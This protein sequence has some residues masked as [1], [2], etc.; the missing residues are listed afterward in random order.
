VPP[1]PTFERQTLADRLG[2]DAPAMAMLHAL[3]FLDVES[4]HQM[5][6]RMHI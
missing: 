2:D 3:A 5:S 6:D 4:N 1:K